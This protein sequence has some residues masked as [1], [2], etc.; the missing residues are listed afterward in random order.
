VPLALSQIPS[1]SKAK[2]PTPDRLSDVSGAEELFC[3]PISESSGPASPVPTGRGAG[4]LAY[5]GC[6]G[7]IEIVEPKSVTL[8]KYWQPLSPPARGHCGKRGARAAAELTVPKTTEQ[9]MSAQIS[10]FTV[11]PGF[12]R[13]P[14]PAW[15]KLTSTV[16]VA[17]IRRRIQACDQD[18]RTAAPQDKVG[19]PRSGAQ[20]PGEPRQD[21]RIRV[22]R[23]LGAGET[24]AAGPACRGST[25]P[26]GP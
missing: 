1:P 10:R 2:A 8:I 19:R 20:R 23:R 11:T 18:D 13:F 17:E 6:E 15:A 5:D 22:K 12:E 3:T 16:A 4:L 21:R 26:S 9:K 25:R 14:L 7:S 24:G